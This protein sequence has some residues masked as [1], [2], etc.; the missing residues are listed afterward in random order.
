MPK[1]AYLYHGTEEMT[2]RCLIDLH[3]HLFGCVVHSGWSTRW[4]R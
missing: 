3:A 1:V 2:Q 4:P